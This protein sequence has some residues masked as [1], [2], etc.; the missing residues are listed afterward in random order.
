MYLIDTNIMNYRCMWI[1]LMTSAPSLCKENSCCWR[2][3]WHFFYFW[4]GALC[5]IPFLHAP[6]SIPILIATSIF[7]SIF[8]LSCLGDVDLLPIWLL[9]LE[10]YSWYTANIVSRSVFNALSI[11]GG[12][13]VA[14]LLCIKRD[15]H[16]IV[17]HNIAAGRV[18][19]YT[20]F[21]PTLP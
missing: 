20:Y 3:K 11:G 14:V 17:T 10:Y 21:S 8:L 12:L 5:S 1:E 15:D 6:G 13:V 18:N 16:F 19:T 9:V 4:S 7:F 2:K